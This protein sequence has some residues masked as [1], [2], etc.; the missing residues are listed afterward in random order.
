MSERELNEKVSDLVQL[1]LYCLQ[2]MLSIKDCLVLLHTH[3]QLT[4]SIDLI[5]LAHYFVAQSEHRLVQFGKFSEADVLPVSF[6]GKCKA[7]SSV[8]RVRNNYI[9]TSMFNVTI[10]DNV[11]SMH[12][13]LVT[14][15][16]QKTY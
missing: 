11:A 16:A 1:Y 13:H 4:E 9:Y 10:R 6:C 12:D 3:K 14:V 5:E 2:S 7:C 15:H 8:H